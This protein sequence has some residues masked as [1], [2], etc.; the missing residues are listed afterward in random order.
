[1]SALRPLRI[2]MYHEVAAT[3][4][5]AFAKYAVTPRAFTRQMAW[6][7]RTG[8]RSVLPDDLVAAR[9]GRGTL[10]PKPVM[11]T[12][13]D[14]YQSCL[15]HAVPALRQHGFT[16]VFYLVAGLVGSTSRW[17]RTELGLELPLFDWHAARELERQGFACEAHS[18]THPHLAQLAPAACRYELED[19]RRILERELGREVRHLAYPFGSY[20]AGVRTLAQEAGYR[21]A[22][23]VR[24]GLSPPDD[25]LLALHRVPVSGHDSLLDFVCRLRTALGVREALGGVLDKVRRQDHPRTAG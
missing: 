14:G 2:L 18:L 5:P 23:S 11:I 15:V 3:A 21:T 6:L 19:S 22:C 1:M 4:P 16:A 12:F 24:I 13:D 20:D 25:D 9:A 7:A 10:P 8:Y 17:L